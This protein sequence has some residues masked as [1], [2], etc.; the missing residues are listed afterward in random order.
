MSLLL[1][2]EYY[3]TDKHT[4]LADVREKNFLE[5]ARVAGKESVSYWYGTSLSTV[6]E[7]AATGKLCITSLDLQGVQV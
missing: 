5:V 2:R 4:L 3:F 6:R 7:V 1:D